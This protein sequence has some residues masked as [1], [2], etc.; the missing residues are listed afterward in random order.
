MN[1][2][3]IMKKAE[4][5]LKENGFTNMDYVISLQGPTL[6]L[7]K[8]GVDKM[9]PELKEKIKATQIEIL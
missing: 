3:E 1:K 5:I 7:A 8:S 4:D 6:I 2:F 9:T